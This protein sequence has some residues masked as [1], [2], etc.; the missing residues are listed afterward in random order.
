MAS[1]PLNSGGFEKYLN[2][3]QRQVSDF[4]RLLSPTFM[5]K[6]HSESTAVVSTS[7]TLTTNVRMVVFRRPQVA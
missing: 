6:M 3:H 7:G 1:K 5:R 2:F 4:L